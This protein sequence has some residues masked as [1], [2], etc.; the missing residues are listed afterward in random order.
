LFGLGLGNLVGWGVVWPLIL[1]AV[2]VGIFLT[3]ILNR[4]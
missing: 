1:I 3:A 2:G 4:G